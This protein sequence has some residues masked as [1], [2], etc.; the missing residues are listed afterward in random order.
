MTVEEFDAL[1]NRLSAAGNVRYNITILQERKKELA[2]GRV[3]FLQLLDADRNPLPS[4][5]GWNDNAIPI[6][7]VRPAIESFIDSRIADLEQQL[8]VL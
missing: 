7:T 8:A 6:E 1:Q 4:C 3:Q 5:R 2:D